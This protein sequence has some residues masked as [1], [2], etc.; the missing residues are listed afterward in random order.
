MTELEYSFHNNAWEEELLAKNPGDRVCAARLLTL[1]EEGD[2]EQVEQAVQLLA[3]KEL[4][5]DLSALPPAPGTGAAAERLLR[6]QKLVEQGQIPDGLEE[7]DPLRLYLEEI[8]ATPAAGDPQLLAESLAAGNRDVVEQLLN[9]MLSKV[10]EE[11]KAYVGKGVLLADLCQEASLGL[12]QSIQEFTGGDFEAHSTRW[13]R[14]YLSSA[15]M[16]QAREAGVGQ[17]LR[18]A[19]EDYR[20]VDERL[21]AEL[22]RNPTVEEIAEALHI[23]APEAATIGEMLENARMLQRVKAPET[24]ELPEEEDQAVEDTAYFQMRQRISELLSGLGEEDARL[25]NL[26]YGLE[27]GLPMKPE[28]VAARM[29]LSL[30]EVV[31]REAAALAVLRQDK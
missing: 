10:V 19:L 6:E 3:Q 14:H 29:G 7:N 1:L 31:S 9:V 15:V 4:V 5:L 16:L 12:W 2:E 28:E 25:L 17:K 30:E 11:A 21:L 20:S 13:I 26:R 27:G 22:G 8:A 24:T 18:R 23:S